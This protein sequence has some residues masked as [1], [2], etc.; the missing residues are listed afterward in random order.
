MSTDLE[1]CFEYNTIN[2][3]PSFLTNSAVSVSTAR[4]VISV[5]KR[6]RLMPINSNK[7]HSHRIACWTPT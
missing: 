2:T 3:S 7:S 4:F 5:R 6:I 1:Q